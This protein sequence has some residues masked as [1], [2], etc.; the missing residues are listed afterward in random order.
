MAGAHDR[1]DTP[2]RL[3]PNELDGATRAILGVH[4]RF[5]LSCFV[6]APRADLEDTRVP[7]TARPLLV[8]GGTN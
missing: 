4:G 5:F 3:A 2:P 7:E 6:Q 8:T 1:E